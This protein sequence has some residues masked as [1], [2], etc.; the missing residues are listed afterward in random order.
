MCSL[1]VLASECHQ[2]PCQ[3]KKLPR[4]LVLFPQTHGSHSAGADRH[5]GAPC[6][7]P[8]SGNEYVRGGLL[9]HPSQVRL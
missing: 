1:G 8:A 6:R 7:T 5:V 2:S 9:H 3:G 4:S